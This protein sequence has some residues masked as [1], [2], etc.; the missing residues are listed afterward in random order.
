MSSSRKH[1]LQQVKANRAAEFELPSLD[2][3]WQ[4]F[5]DPLERFCEVLTSTGGNSLRVNDL[6]SANEWFEQRISGNA[7][8]QTISLVE[9]V[10]RSTLELD[11]LETPQELSGLDWAI[12]PAEFGVA[13]NGALWVTDINAK[14][15]AVYYLCEHLVLVL[16]ASQV[17][18]NM[19]QAYERLA[20]FAT[21]DTPPFGC[22][23]AGPSK[24]ADIEQ[25]LVIGAQGPRSLDV[26]LIV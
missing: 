24:T 5:G 22:F 12:L 8:S 14:H 26:L 3:D 13:E 25:S 18:H 21:D 15:R 10:G 20:G 6:A 11:Q 7:D 23:I 4:T 16:P 2:Q 19:P 17:V 1:I 9:G